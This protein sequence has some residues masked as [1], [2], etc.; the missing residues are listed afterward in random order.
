MEQLE[1]DMRKSWCTAGCGKLLTPEEHKIHECV[2]R[3]NESKKARGIFSMK[4]TAEDDAFERGRIR[5]LNDAAAQ[6]LLKA[7]TEGEG[8]AELLSGSPALPPKVYRVPEQPKKET[9]QEDTAFDLY[10]EIDSELLKTCKKAFQ[11]LRVV[12]PEHKKDKWSNFTS[13]YGI[14]VPLKFAFLPPAVKPGSEKRNLSG[15]VNFRIVGLTEEELNLFNTIAPGYLSKRKKKRKN[16]I[17]RF[18]DV[19]LALTLL[20][21]DPATFRITS[22]PHFDRRRGPRKSKPSAVVPD[23]EVNF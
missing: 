17:G 7:G 3:D 9:Y 8:V 14:P 19:K 16:T 11:G 18:T 6:R 2:L 13:D 21:K 23:V 20:A 5:G 10:K 4:R 15:H 1:L 12:A 22:E